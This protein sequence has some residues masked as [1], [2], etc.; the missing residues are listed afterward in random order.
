MNQAFKEWLIEDSDKWTPVE[1]STFLRLA[2][3]EPD[4]VL[5][6]LSANLNDWGIVFSIRTRTSLCVNPNQDAQ[7]LFAAYKE[8]FASDLAAVSK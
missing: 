6:I 4:K 2:K 5:Q 8:H 7:D 1:K 3:F